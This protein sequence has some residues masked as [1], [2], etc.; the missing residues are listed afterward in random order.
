[1][2]ASGSCHTLLLLCK[3]FDDV[4][5]AD[6]GVDLEAL[7]QPKLARHLTEGGC[8]TKTEADSVAIGAAEEFTRGQRATREMFDSFDE[9][10]GYFVPLLALGA[11]LAGIYVMEYLKNRTTK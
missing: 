8:V 9:N 2:V 3:L 11:T 5:A 10:N 1:M 7:A 6:L 4:C